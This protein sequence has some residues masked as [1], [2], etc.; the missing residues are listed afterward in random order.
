MVHS[1]VV[2]ALVQGCRSRKCCRR[3]LQAGCSSRSSSSCTC[4]RLLKR[5]VAAA[6][7]RK[8]E[9]ARVTPI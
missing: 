5:Q 7:G 8:D 4:R 2:A 1:V 6:V 9:V 3:R